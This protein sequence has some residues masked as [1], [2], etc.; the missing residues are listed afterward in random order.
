[1]KTQETFLVPSG[2]AVGTGRARPAVSAWCVRPARTG[3]PWL[4]TDE[5]DEFPRLSVEVKLVIVI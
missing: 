3:A 5:N 1:M 2:G 4:P